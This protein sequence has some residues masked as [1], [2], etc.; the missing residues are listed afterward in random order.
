MKTPFLLGIFL[1]A[2]F[3]DVYAQQFNFN[4]FSVPITRSEKNDKEIIQ[5]VVKDTYDHISPELKDVANE[6][7]FV[8]DHNL[9]IS[10]TAMGFSAEDDQNYKYPDKTFYHP[11][12][13]RNGTI[14]IVL[15][16]KFVQACDFL[17]ELIGENQD[18]PKIIE[19]AQGF[20]RSI[21]EHELLHAW[22]Y[23]TSPVPDL[24]RNLNFV[25]SG[26]LTMEDLIQ[27][28]RK[29]VE[30]ERAAFFL[31]MSHAKPGRLETLADATEE[32]MKN[33]PEDFSSNGKYSLLSNLYSS[34]FVERYLREAGTNV[35][36]YYLTKQ[37]SKRW[38]L[39]YEGQIRPV[40]IAEEMKKI[41]KD[42]SKLSKKEIKMLESLNAELKSFENEP[43]W[44]DVTLKQHPYLSD[45]VN[46]A[47]VIFNNLSEKK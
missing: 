3:S 33:H 8:I 1:T 7:T 18:K 27:G 6:V 46:Q 5:T 21:L 37:T 11:Y 16:E 42:K 19:A 25:A 41:T 29:K 20:Y 43:F 28:T 2:L 40:E 10:Q 35:K 34:P 31:T 30:N 47:H 23:H 15:T 24:D 4:I 22:H 12:T 9:E 13:N 38:D 44:N 32:F 39:I 45:Y 17:L 36:H 14:K 26:E